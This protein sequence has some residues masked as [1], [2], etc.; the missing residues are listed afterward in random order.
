LAR[1]IKRIYEKDFQ[2][3]FFPGNTETGQSVFYLNDAVEA[4]VRT[5]ERRHQIE[6]ETAILIGEPDPPSYETLQ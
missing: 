2:S 4:I 1:Q 3:F 6:P 5:V